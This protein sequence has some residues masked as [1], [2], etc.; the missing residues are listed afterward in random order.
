MA[1]KKAKP[2]PEGLKVEEEAVVLCFKVLMMPISPVKGSVRRACS[3]CGQP[4][5][6]SPATAAHV[7]DRPYKVCC[8]ECA[9]NQ[10]DPDLHVMPPSE[11]QIAEMMATDPSISAARVRRAFPASNPA[12]RR[13]SVEEMLKQARRRKRFDN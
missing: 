12:K 4:V 11:L 13:K 8:M 6:I 2:E 3:E 10:D 1:R 9:A 7:A 5:W